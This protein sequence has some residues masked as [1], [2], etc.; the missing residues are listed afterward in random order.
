MLW[1]SLDNGPSAPRVT[2]E[3]YAED[4]AWQLSV[5]VVIVDCKS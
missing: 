2:F 5:V 4:V 3:S 1:L